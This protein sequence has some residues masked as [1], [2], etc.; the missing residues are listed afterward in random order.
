MQ[1]SQL[2]R[3]AGR[4][5]WCGALAIIAACSASDG[6]T[7]PASVDGTDTSDSQMLRNPLA[8]ARL[9]VFPN[10]HAQKTADSWRVT[11]PADAALMDRIAGQPQ[12]E[13]FGDWNTDVLTDVSAAVTKAATA[14]AAPVLV[15]YDIPLRD[16]GSYSAGGAASSDAYRAW[17]SAFARGIGDR[18]AVVILEPDAL[19]GVDCLTPAQSAERNSLISFAIQQLKAQAATSVYVDAGNSAWHTPATIA[20]R[21][22]NAGIALADG[23]SLNVS[24]FLFA[25]DEVRFGAAVSNRVGNKHYVI[26]TSR[27]GLGPTADY[28]WCN[29]EGRALGALPTTKTGIARVDA[30]LWIKLPGESDG[31]CNGY[32]SSGT[33]LPEYALGLA[34]RAA[35]TAL[36]ASGGE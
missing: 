33:W 2:L 31:A 35:G 22:T 6:P 8:D 10:S 4:S 17:I 27:N 25:A 21:L 3:A 23:F 30:F 18:R 7:A 28:Q 12:A 26:D 9:F 34:Q 13:W 29:P 32:P 5:A 36:L 1:P 20:S 14:G 15:A 11:R 24:N 16:C 19:A